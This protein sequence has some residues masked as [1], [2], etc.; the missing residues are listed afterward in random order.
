MKGFAVFVQY[1]KNENHDYKGKFPYCWFCVV[2]I[3]DLKG[4][5]PRVVFLSMGISKYQYYIRKKSSNQVQPIILSINEM[6]ILRV[7]V[8]SCIVHIHIIGPLLT[9]GSTKI[10]I[11][12][13]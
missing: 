11:D 9:T 4:N 10:Q 8:I 2:V 12:A 13:E 3:L 5:I 1:C 7:M 6:I